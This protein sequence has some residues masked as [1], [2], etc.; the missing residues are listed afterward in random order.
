MYNEIMEVIK[1]AWSEY[2]QPYIL[3]K[4]GDQSGYDQ[5]IFFPK[6]SD[7]VQPN[8]DI[9]MLMNVSTNA[10]R[11]FTFNEDNNDFVYNAGFNGTGYLGNIPVDSIVV[12][13]DHNDQTILWMPS[14][15]LVIGKEP[16]PELKPYDVVCNAGNN[17]LLSIVANNTNPSK[18][19]PTYVKWAPV[20]I[21]K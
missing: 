6:G 20:I 1:K 18:T 16:E 19:S 12:I 4:V 17:P 7:K 10:C 13:Y 14:E 11:S 2:R 15:G 8:G 3:Y 9:T 21:G 5:R